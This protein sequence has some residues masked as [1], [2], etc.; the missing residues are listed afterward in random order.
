MSHINDGKVAGQWIQP[1][2]W[3]SQQLTSARL[4]RDDR[5]GRIIIGLDSTSSPM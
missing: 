3:G 1:D 2:L 5:G 4:N